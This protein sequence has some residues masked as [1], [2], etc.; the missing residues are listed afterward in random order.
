MWLVIYSTLSHFFT[1]TK[2]INWAMCWTYSPW[3]FYPWSKLFWNAWKY[4]EN[5]F[6]LKLNVNHLLAWRRLI[7]AAAYWVCSLRA[8]SFNGYL[9]ANCKAD[10]HGFKLKKNK[11]KQP[12]LESWKTKRTKPSLHPVNSLCFPSFIFHPMYYSALVP[13][14]KTSW[15]MVLL[16]KKPDIRGL[17]KT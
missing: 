6:H 15:I 2:P 3:G 8:N 11:C 16:W 17:Q 7:Q 5:N 13:S 9:E 10:R 14:W 4:L 1:G 12:D